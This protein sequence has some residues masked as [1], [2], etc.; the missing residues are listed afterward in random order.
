ARFFQDLFEPLGGQWIV[1]S[2][3]GP[4]GYETRLARLTA[5]SRDELERQLT[6]LGSRLV[7]LIDWNRARKRLSRF[8]G[9]TDAVAVLRWAADQGVGHRAFL[10]AGGERL[11][12]QALERIPGTHLRYG[13]RLDEVVGADMARRFLMAVLRI[14][15]DGQEHGRS[16]RFVRDEVEAELIELFHETQ[17]GA[18]ALVAD[19]AALLSS[20]AVSLRDAVLRTSLDGAATA[21]AL[22]AER[23]KRWETRADELVRTART[24]VHRTSGG[25]WVGRLLAVADDV[26]DG[27]EEATFLLTL[28]QQRGA[29]AQA[30]AALQEL[31]ELTVD[32]TREY[33]KA[34]ETARDIR[35]GGAREDVQDFLVAIDRLVTIEHDSDAAERRAQTVFLDAVSDFRELHLLSQLSSRLEEATDAVARCALML[36]DHV[37]GDVMAES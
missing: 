16:L 29:G 25:D 37:L 17:Q 27:L 1:R 26:A 34:V 24:A 22:A 2:T 12:G 6:Y 8:L 14:T 9:K 36:K 30:L 10:E 32:G 3:A 13:A 20:I 7:F 11:I 31:A 15:H 19:H 33:I 23:S 4:G 35:R 28:L 5:S 21:P 18:L